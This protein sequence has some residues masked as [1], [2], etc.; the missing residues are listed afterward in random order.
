MVIPVVTSYKYLGITVSD[1]LSLK[2]NME[3]RK[4]LNQSL[5]MKLDCLSFQVNDIGTRSAIQNQLIRAKT[6][7]AAEILTPFCKTLKSFFE[8][9]VKIATVAT[10]GLSS[11]IN[12]SQAS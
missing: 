4:H 11:K 8:Q 10:F 5:V 7:Y 3:S 1:G 6:S 2:T 9:S 12:P